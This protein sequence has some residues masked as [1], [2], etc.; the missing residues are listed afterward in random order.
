MAANPADRIEAALAL[1]EA[2]NELNNPAGF[3]R[4]LVESGETIP[5]PLSQ[6]RVLLE[7][8]AP[9]PKRTQGLLERLEKVLEEDPGNP[10]AKFNL[11]RLKSELSKVVKR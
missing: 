2:S 6:R 1:V 3:L 8:S 5:V 9:D 4:R 10:A 7:V 11:E